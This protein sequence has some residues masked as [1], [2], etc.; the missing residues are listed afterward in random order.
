[1]LCTTI[2]IKPDHK[3]EVPNQNK[4]SCKPNQLL[5]PLLP[6]VV[7]IIPLQVLARPSF[8]ALPTNP[9]ATTSAARNKSPTTSTA[10]NAPLRQMSASVSGS[11][12]PPPPRPRQ[13][14][15]IPNNAKPKLRARF[16]NVPL[17]SKRAHRAANDAPTN[18]PHSAPTRA[19]NR[20]GRSRFGSETAPHRAR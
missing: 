5:K 17:T 13:I 10:H 6:F 2:V 7:V 4:L 12:L 3:N 18:K 8:R 15:A 9:N 1:M 14:S 20:F 11:A 16:P 19:P